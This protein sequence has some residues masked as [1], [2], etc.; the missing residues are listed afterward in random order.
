MRPPT[1]N[2]CTIA[3]KYLLGSVG[4]AIYCIEGAPST[5]LKSQF[6]LNRFHAYTISCLLELLKLHNSTIP[7]S[8]LKEERVAREGE[9]ERERERGESSPLIRG[10]GQSF[11]FE[12]RG[13]LAA[14]LESAA[15]RPTTEPPLIPPPVQI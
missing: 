5:E 2:V 10:M 7:A 6:G 14:A 11:S 4:H 15:N 8:S 3:W 13:L 9:R 12:F 1:G